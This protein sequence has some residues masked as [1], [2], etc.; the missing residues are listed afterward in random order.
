[1]RCSPYLYNNNRHT[2]KDTRGN[3]TDER[4]CY[5]QDAYSEDSKEPCNKLLPD[6]EGELS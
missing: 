2:G 4:I 3:V 5:I 1:M 6:S